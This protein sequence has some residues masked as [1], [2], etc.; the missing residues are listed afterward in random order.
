[1]SNA[2]NVRIQMHSHND[3]EQDFPLS[4]ALSNNFK[5]IEVDVLEFNDK[6]IVSHD[7]DKL[8]LKPTLKDLYL[9][10]LSK[11]AFQE[12]QTIY[13][14]IDLK[15]EGDKILNVLHKLLNSYPQLF[16]N[17][18]D[19]SNN[20]PIQVI[21]SGSVDIDFVISNDSF[22][23]F[24]VDGRPEHLFQKYDSH[25]MP[26]ISYNF[27]DLFSWKPTKKITKSN[28]DPIINLI[29]TT[30]QEGKIMRFWNTPDEPD[31]WDLLLALKV[32]IIGVD[33]IEKFVTYSTKFNKSTF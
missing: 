27:E 10:P 4:K 5:S 1:M 12:N 26:L 16:K 14:L 21:L 28:I 15:M 8:Q 20:S 25:L 30:H 7:D 9:E 19:D 33:D 13:L 3:Y 22:Y 17:R 23:Y 29:K 31:L 2:Q 24:F 6:I 18:Y 32:D 11:Y